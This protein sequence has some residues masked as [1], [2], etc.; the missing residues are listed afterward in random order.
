MNEYSPIFDY[1]WPVIEMADEQKGSNHSSGLETT[2]EFRQLRKVMKEIVL[3]V[4]DGIGRE[5][6]E[7][8]AEMKGIKGDDFKNAIASLTSS[9]HLYYDDKSEKFHYV[10]NE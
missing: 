3:S 9:G 4:P 5:E 6:L 10:R 1:E 7:R 2:R 8:S